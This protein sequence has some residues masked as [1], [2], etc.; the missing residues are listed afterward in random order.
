MGIIKRKSCGRLHLKCDDTCT[1]TRSCLSVK[2]MSP[3]KL[4]EGLQF[5]RLLATEVCISAVVMLD[6]QCSEVV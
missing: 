2:Q 4:A 6:A 1:E 3:L 5:S